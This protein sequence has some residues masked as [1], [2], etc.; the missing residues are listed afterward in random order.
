MELSK[1]ET[2]KTEILR[3]LDACKTCDI[4]E[5]ELEAAR[6]YLV[7]DLKIAMDSPG[8]LD[9]YYMGQILL[10]Q[11]GT[12]QDLAEK[13]AH[14]TKQEAADAAKTLRLDTIYALKGV[15]A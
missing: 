10:D 4:T 8:R 5:E 9:D 12:M 6:G 7:S 15:T 14:V 1:L 3:Q 2:A 11:T 13:I